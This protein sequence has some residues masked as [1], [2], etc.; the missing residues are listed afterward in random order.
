VSTM[1]PPRQRPPPIPHHP[2][3]LPPSY[4]E[5][6]DDSQEKRVNR[7]DNDDDVDERC[8]PCVQCICEGLIP[9][10][11][12][13]AILGFVLYTELWGPE[14]RVGSNAFAGG[15]GRGRGRG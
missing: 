5:S 9:L 13:L 6:H 7:R 10:V 3:P 8:Y 1:Y 15:R 4:Y 12:C 2:P 14:P 11:F